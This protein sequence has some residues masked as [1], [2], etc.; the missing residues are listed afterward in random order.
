MKES[1]REMRIQF[2]EGIEFAFSRITVRG[3]N[4]EVVSQGKQRQL[5]ND[6][7]AI[8]LRPLRPSRSGRCYP[9]IPTSPKACCISL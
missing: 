6:T 1:L 3:L 8:D 2:T 4:G 5:A 7:V 9:W